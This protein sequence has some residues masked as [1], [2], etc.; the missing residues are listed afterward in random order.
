MASIVGGA[1]WFSVL[2]LAN[3]FFTVPLHWDIYYKFAFTFQEKQLCFA[4]VPMGWNNA[5][6]I[7][8]AHVAKMWEGMTESDSVISYVDDILICTQTPEENLK[9]LDRVL[10]KIQET[11]FKVSL[12]KA[13]QVHYLGLTLGQEGCS[14]NQQRVELILN[15]PAPTD[16]TALRSF[17]GMVN[18]SRDFIEGILEK[19]APLHEL[20]KKGTEWTWGLQQ[21]EAMAQLKQALAQALAAGDGGGGGGGGGAR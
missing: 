21:Q 19:A 8:H 17:L 14:P 12:K 18:F 11:G 2:D 10:Q 6:I 1:Q 20:L 9:V 3:A 4:R 13:Q 5:P 15:L 16:I 7:C